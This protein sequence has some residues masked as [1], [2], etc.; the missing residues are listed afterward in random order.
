MSA[1]GPDLSARSAPGEPPDV[2]LAG[3]PDDR[4]RAPS[5]GPL[6]LVLRGPADVPELLASRAVVMAN[7]TRPLTGAEV[8]HPGGGLLVMDGPPLA[9]LR[10][11]IGGLFSPAAARVTVPAAETAARACLARMAQG[12]S[13]DLIA[14]YA[15]PSV[16]GLVC[17]TLGR[18]PGDWEYIKTAGQVAFG[19][20]AS[21][22]A[23]PGA[24]AMWKELYRYYRPIVAET[25]SRPAPACLVRDITRR[26]GA[27][28][29]GP[30]VIVRVVATVSNGFQAVLPV[31]GR[32]LTEL[33]RDPAA[34][35]ACLRGQRDWAAVVDGLIGT[36]A[37]FPVALPR[38]VTEDVR[39]GT[40]LIPAGTQVLPSLVAAGRAGAPSS[41]AFGRGAHYCPGAALTRAWVTTGVRVF[42]ERFPNA[43][44]TASG[45]LD[46]DD[47]TLPVPRT[48]RVSLR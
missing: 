29:C 15:E 22:H 48:L 30:A 2:L 20:I 12:R 32:C 11:V 36:V 47:A 46:W 8:Q 45:E 16:A 28:G 43:R 44:L 6:M 25:L 10:S 19:V 17:A 42:F 4:V 31:L 39:I 24:R 34:V 7:R 14:G 13:A 23:I 37:L 41:I 9:A 33:L 21:R 5:G 38:L 35:A 1:S 26:L 27:A 18:P 40:R 3:G